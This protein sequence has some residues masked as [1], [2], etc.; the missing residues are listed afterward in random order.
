MTTFRRSLFVQAAAAGLALAL[1]AAPARAQALSGPPAWSTAGSTG[2]VDESNTSIVAFGNTGN[3][4][5][6]P[7]AAAGSI[8]TVRYPV[9]FLPTHLYIDNSNV[10]FYA[11]DRLTL[12]M[13]FRKPDDNSYASATLKRVRLSDGA[14]S[15][16]ASVNTFGFLPGAAFQQSE[17]TVGCGEEVA[18]INA[19]EYAYFIELVLWKPESTNDPQVVG[20]RVYTS[21]N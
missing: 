8:A 20:L 9:S 17:R 1:G 7:T 15:N 11:F 4:S 2:I 5:L 21:N 19:A 6:K 13:T 12:S 10:I 16:M 14:V 18:C 3:V